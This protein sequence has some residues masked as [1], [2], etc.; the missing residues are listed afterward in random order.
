MW[1]VVLE[2]THGR[3]RLPEIPGMDEYERKEYLR[4]NRRRPIEETI[5]DVGEGRGTT[6]R[7]TQSITHAL[8]TSDPA[9]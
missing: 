3:T 8:D 1:V 4:N 7:H 2:S 9:T 5:A 6:L